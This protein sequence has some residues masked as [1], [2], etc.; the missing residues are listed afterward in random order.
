[1]DKYIPLIE[2]VSIP[3]RVHF[4]LGKRSDKPSIIGNIIYY[5]EVPRNKSVTSA[6]RTETGSNLGKVP[7]CDLPILWYLFIIV[8]SS[9]LQN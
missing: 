2:P 8:L 3:C 5:I 7:F 6:L 9:F 1:M 4:S